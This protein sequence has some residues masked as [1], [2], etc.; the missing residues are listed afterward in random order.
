MSPDPLP[1]LIVKTI[2]EGGKANQLLRDHAADSTNHCPC[3][4][5]LSPCT[6]FVAAEKAWNLQSKAK[7]V[8][9]QT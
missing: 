3:C 6:L 9:E 4:H 8:K 7:L 1:A 2:R 5:Q